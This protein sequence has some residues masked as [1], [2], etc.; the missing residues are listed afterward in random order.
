MRRATAV[1]LLLAAAITAAGCGNPT[2]RP[3][4]DVRGTAKCLE[5][6]GYRVRT[7]FPDLVASTASRG[8]LRASKNYNLLTVAFGEDAREA[9]SLRR[10]YARYMSKRRARHIR[11]IT[12]I[13]RNALLLWTTTPSSRQLDAVVGCLR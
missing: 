5:G 13:E 4:G 8:A 11:D 2:L 6:Q 9:A 12:E 10:A 3:Y 7:Q 1:I